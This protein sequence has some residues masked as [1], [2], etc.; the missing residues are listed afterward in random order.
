MTSLHFFQ[1]ALTAELASQGLS[2]E[3][4][5]GG[6]DPLVIRR[7]K[8]AALH[9]LLALYPPLMGDTGTILFLQADHRSAKDVLDASLTLAAAYIELVEHKLDVTPMM[10]K[11]GIPPH[12]RMPQP[13]SNP[14]ATSASTLNL[15]NP[16][17]PSLRPW[18]IIEPRFSPPK[19]KPEPKPKL[20]EAPPTWPAWSWRGG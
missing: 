18:G 5:F 13:P 20:E 17:P 19:P 10:R 9:T 16:P 6:S 2:L 4:V 8:T 15:A 3:M 12:P 7:V 1:S 11:A 14:R